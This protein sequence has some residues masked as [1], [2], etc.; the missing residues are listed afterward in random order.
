MPIHDK[1]NAVVQWDRTHIPRIASQVLSSYNNQENIIYSA[2]TEHVVVWLPSSPH[3]STTT[4]LWLQ[5]LQTSNVCPIEHR[6]HLSSKAQA[7]AM[8][9]H[10]AYKVAA[11]VLVSFSLKPSMDDYQNYQQ[12]IRWNPSWV[13]T[14]EAATNWNIITSHI[15]SP[16]IRLGLLLTIRN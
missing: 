15:Q 8:L 16:E 12:S 13:L 7:K 5:Y 11:L 1:S 3:M 9:F 6:K 10:I 2:T 4:L 14:N